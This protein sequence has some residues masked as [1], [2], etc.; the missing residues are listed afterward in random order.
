MLESLFFPGMNSNLFRN[1]TT[2]FPAPAALPFEI[3]DCVFVLSGYLGNKLSRLKC[4][5]YTAIEKF[6]FDVFKLYSISDNFC[7]LSKCCIF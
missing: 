3:L 6:L 2:V 1:I 5:P 7:K 4:L